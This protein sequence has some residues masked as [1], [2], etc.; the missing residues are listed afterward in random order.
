MTDA[1]TTYDQVPYP[2]LSYTHTHPDHLATVARLMGLESAPPA[3]CRM[4][5]LGCASGG[6]LMPMAYA[7]PESEFIGIDNSRVQIDEGQ[8]ALKK[9]GLENLDLRYMDIM[10]VDGDLGQFDYVVAHGI[11]SWVPHEVQEKLL[12]VCRANLAPNGVAFVSYNTYPGWHLIEIARGIMR[13]HTRDDVDPQQRATRARAILDEFV[14]AMADQHTVYGDFLSIYAETLKDAHKSNTP[15][16]NA[17][18]LHDEMEDLNQPYYFYQFVERAEE[19]GLQYLG[20]ADF[21]KM[22]GTN[23]GPEGQKI[24]SQHSKSVIDVEQYMD[25]LRNRTLR[26]TLLCHQDVEVRR[27]LR[28]ETIQ[29]FCMA[30]KAKPESDDPDIHAASVEKFLASDGAA[31]AMDHPTSKAAMIHMA[32]VWPASVPFDELLSEARAYLGLGASDGDQQQDAQ[33]L[34]ANLFKAYSYSSELVDLHTHAPP[35]VLEIGERPMVSPVARMQATKSDMVTNQRHER[36]TLDEIDLLLLQH[37]DGEHD[38]AALIEWL[39]KGPVAQGKMAIEKDGQEVK[40]KTQL[41]TLLAE[42]VDKKLRWLRYAALLA[43]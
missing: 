31:L 21:R 20:E 6:N 42:G 32:K 17:F 27:K 29:R 8:E 5:E 3:R 19:H 39:E 26:Q 36:V 23:F 1:R 38:R 37:L 34:A 4:L 30:S 43:G 35:V 22:T 18:L 24:L 33:V 13:Y 40:D 16:G 10:D 25:F 12:D 11:F 7:L 2:S 14:E 41:R 15:A 28:P 9:L